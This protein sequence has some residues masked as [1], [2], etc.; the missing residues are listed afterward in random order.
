MVVVFQIIATYAPYIYLI[1]GLTALYQLYRLWQVREER[2]QAIFML[3][4]ER[5]VR[6]LSGIFSVA[7]L[8]L[9]IMGFTYFASRTIP[10][11]IVAAP[12]AEP[13]L[14]PQ[15]ALVITPTNT[16]LPVTPSPTPTETATPTPEPPTPEPGQP[17]PIESPPTPTPEPAPIAQAGS[18]PTCPDAR[19]V[20][21]S[22]GNGATVSGVFTLIGTATHEQFSYYK[23]E[24]AP[25]ANAQNG[26]T[27]L[28]DGRGPVFNGALASINS[29]GFANGPWT[30][31][32]TVVDLTGNYP[33]PCRV[34]LY[35]EN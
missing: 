15:F 28:A 7:M 6:E 8:L 10:Q 3:E 18:P 4:R 26:F 1:C 19:A 27:Y 21:A 25:G 23:V 31:Q 20:I 5:A 33:E 22:P 9:V 12:E 17:Q 32:L 34:T 13:T 14:P 29:R 30:F 2:R 16:P 11:A 35:I 24:F